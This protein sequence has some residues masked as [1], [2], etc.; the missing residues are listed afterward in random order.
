MLSILITH[1]NRPK[2]LQEC[3]CS[4]RGFDFGIEYEIVVSDDCSS[5]ENINQIKKLSID[6]LLISN[7][8][9]GLANNLNKG[10]RACKGSYILYVQEDFTIDKNFKEVFQEGLALLREDVLDMVR[11]RANYTFSKLYNCSKNIFI[12]PTFSFANFNINTFQYSDHPFLTTSKF[13]KRFGYYLENT[14]GPYGETEY[15][16]R[17][18]KSKA[19][20]GITKKNYFHTIDVMST[21]EPKIINQKFRLNKSTRRFARALRQHLE[22]ILY[23]PKK[24]KL[25]TYKNKKNVRE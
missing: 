3:I 6:N 16:I 15:S 21:I 4:I 22:W 14:S 20:I 9:A 25:Y 2:A 12:I 7:K 1:F 24:R 13:Y 19:K 23:N 5:I 8:N 17:L 11:F 18:M 10:I